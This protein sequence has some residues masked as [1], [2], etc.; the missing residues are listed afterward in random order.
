MMNTEF[1]E[2][3]KL[4]EK[5]KGIPA[6]YLIEKIQTAVANAIKRDASGGENSIVEIN[7]ETGRFYVAVS[8][9]VVNEVEDPSL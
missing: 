6:N 5:E 7:P 1:F 2:A 8:K 3:I 4:L 9:E